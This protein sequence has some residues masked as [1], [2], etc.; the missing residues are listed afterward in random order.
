LVDG[1]IFDTSRDLVDG[2][3]AGGT[4][5]PHEFQLLRGN[6]IK[7]LDHGIATMSLGEI[8]RFV[9]S[10]ELGYG[11]KGL[12]PL[13]F[14]DDTLDYEIE[15]LRFAPTL[16]KFPSPEEIAESKKRRAEEERKNHEENPPPT[17]DERI[18][19]STKEKEKGNLLFA[20][21]DWEGAKKQYDAAFVHIFISKDAW[22]GG[23]LTDVEMKKVETAKLSLHLNRCICKMKLGKIEDAEWDAT[24][25]TELGPENV[26]GWYRKGTVFKEKL[27]T[28][29][30]KEKDGVFWECSNAQALSDETKASIDT[31]A[32][33]VKDQKLGEKEEKSVNLLMKEWQIQQALL[34]KYTKKYAKDQKVLYKEKIFG[35]LVKGNAAARRKEELKSVALEVPLTY[36]DMP[37]LDDDDSEE[38]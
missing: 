5:D 3:H 24:K 8:A 1:R 37:T 26:K 11:Q 19:E 34:T 27:K 15:L 10:P 25:A 33:L 29:L 18:S 32:K 36:D 38:E 7:G 17:L 28:E 4:D 23:A 30:Q 9:I 21:K 22:E 35:G 13:V 16:P 31:A 12:P 20:A 2:K 14:P 6:W